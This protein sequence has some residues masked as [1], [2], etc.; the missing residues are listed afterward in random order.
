MNDRSPQQGVAYHGHIVYCSTKSLLMID[1][2]K[3]CLARSWQ[4]ILR[5]SW[6]YGKHVPEPSP[7]ECVSFWPDS[8]VIIVER[9]RSRPVMAC[10]SSFLS[11]L[12]H[13]RGSKG[14]WKK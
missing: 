8:K 4:Q 13:S 2:T 9:T 14:D 11:G 3:S 1:E 5:S 12:F 6:Y 7:P 10:E